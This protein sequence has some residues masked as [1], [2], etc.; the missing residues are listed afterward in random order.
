MKKNIFILVVSFIVLSCEEKSLS[1]LEI[2]NPAPSNLENTL[3]DNLSDVG[4]YEDYFYDFNENINVKFLKYEYQHLFLGA[5]FKPE[6]D[7]INFTT[8]P[9][10][11]VSVDSSDS[12][13][14]IDDLTQITESS[15]SQEVVSREFNFEISGPESTI[16]SLKWQQVSGDDYRYVVFS[17]KLKLLPEIESQTGPAI[18]QVFANDYYTNNF[19]KSIFSED[20]IALNYMLIDTV[21]WD[22]T[23]T[24]N[25]ASS[26]LIDTIFQERL[27]SI[28]QLVDTDLP[29]FADGS[30]VPYY[31]DSTGL[32]QIPDVENKSGLSYEFIVDTMVVIGTDLLFSSYTNEEGETI[33]GEKMDNLLTS[34]RSEYFTDLNNNG[35]YD[36]D[37]EP[38]SDLNNNQ[39]YD[40]GEVFVDIGNGVWDEGEEF[41]DVANGS[42]DIG[43]DFVDIGNCQHDDDEIFTDI[44][45]CQYDS[46]ETF[47]DVGNGVWDDNEPFTDLGNEQWDLGEP[48]IDADGN[49]EW[50]DTE[51]FVDSNGNG[52]CD[53]TDNYSGQGG[54]NSCEE[55][56]AS[57]S[58]FGD[59]NFICQNF[60]LGGVPI[61]EICA[62]TCG[63]VEEY[64]DVNGNGAWDLAESFTDL[65]NGVWDEGESYSD[66]NFNGEYDLAEEFVDIGNGTY[67]DCEEFIDSG[68]LNG[69][70]DEGELFTDIG[71]GTW[72]EGEE[73]T[74]RANGIWDEGEDYVDTPNGQYDSCEEFTDVPNGQYDSCE[75][76][77]DVPNGEYDEGELFI[78]VGDGVWNFTDLNNNQICDQNVVVDVADEDACDSV[79]GDWS[80][81]TCTVASEC[82]DFIDLGNGQ[83]DFG[84]TFTD[85]DGN[86]VYDEGE[87][88]EDLGNMIYDQ[89]DT[90]TDVNGNGVWD[91][92][93]PF[94]DYDGD[95]EYDSFIPM[96]LLTIYPGDVLVDENGDI[97]DTILVQIPDYKYYK[98]SSFT[99]I[100][101]AQEVVT[102]H[103]IFESNFD[104]V[105]EYSLA[106]TQT[107]LNYDYHLFNIDTLSNSSSINKYVYPS[108]FY[109]V[110]LWDIQQSEE[111]DPSMY[112]FFG[113]EGSYGFWFDEDN[114]SREA[115]FYLQDG[116]NF[117]DG[118]H[119]QDFEI[120]TTDHAIYYI[121][122]DYRVQRDTV[123]VEMYNGVWDAGYC[124]GSDGLPSSDL[125]QTCIDVGSYWVEDE[126][127]NDCS[128]ECG[129]DGLICEYNVQ[130]ANNDGVIDADEWEENPNYNNQ[131]NGI[132]DVGEQLRDK[133]RF[134]FKNECFKITRVMNM[135]MKGTGI[136][137][138]EMNIT[139]L[140][141]DYSI[142]KDEVYYSWGDEEWIPYSRMM[143]SEF[144]SN[145][146]SQSMASG[147][148]LRNFLSKSQKVRLE[149]FDK[150]PETN[151]KPYNKF[152]SVGIQKI[153]TSY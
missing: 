15:T 110:G 79:G 135:E 150:S 54:Y 61:Y 140:A 127:Y 70:W 5:V 56:I 71:N 119:I 96:E 131:G 11:F 62:E 72:D 120:D 80:S 90:F 39:Q 138:N 99:N 143:M 93:E 116:E 66:L 103:V 89:P 88:F 45:N 128:A 64:T 109:Y 1:S 38:Y 2:D 6:E 55:G 98:T 118:E 121:S 25:Y 73:F 51:P 16:D 17:T 18:S 149:E 141:K 42:W 133:P 44:G 126:K 52:I 19:Q 134:F 123:S 102:N 125:Q 82:E 13:I 9:N 86:G 53:L 57:L 108:Y 75:E 142:V 59:T 12:S 130:D 69:I 32:I 40:V 23:V 122:K 60:Q 147:G 74:D 14:D 95:M 105:S 68:A 85:S 77:T 30:I 104:N 24:Y 78:D 145:V 100:E 31:T 63:I 10:F 36:S 92:G 65:G 4:T 107:G 28:N 81:N 114:G 76:F 132:W 48:Y 113:P 97:V 137:Y 34:Y 146:D 33:L 49:G 153:G 124:I 50:T 7:T 26:A 67:D 21:E 47:T 84:E 115:L 139:W 20:D 58:L 3:N 22:T 94:I 29:Y 136:T 152:R 101:S 46:G 37:P 35:V 129:D 111:A 41:E 27:D 144:R 151:F 8:Y 43:E 91:D 117:R 148:L 87:V 106:K 83:Y 112:D